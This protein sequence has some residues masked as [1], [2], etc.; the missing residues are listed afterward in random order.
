MVIKLRATLIASVL[1]LVSAYAYSLDGACPNE[2][3]GFIELQGVNI[4]YE[5]AGDMQTAVNIQLNESYKG[6][7]LHSVI[8]EQ[9]SWSYDKSGRE[10]SAPD[11]SAEL[12]V[13][14][15]NDNRFVQVFLSNTNQKRKLLIQYGERCGI[16]MKA[17]L[18]VGKKV[19]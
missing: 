1:F 16:I 2:T 11:I 6:L 10:V 8:L 7:S 12:N 14:E 4:E 19:K 9:G 3:P 18:V 5:S 17:D 15:H 13:R